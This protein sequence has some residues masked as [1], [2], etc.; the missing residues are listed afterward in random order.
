MYRYSRQA[1]SLH[2]H[3]MNE[4]THI[5]K[6][7]PV[8]CI[9]VIAAIRGRL[10]LLTQSGGRLL[11]TL[12]I[13]PPQHPRCHCRCPPLVSTAPRSIWPVFTTRAPPVARRAPRTP[14]LTV[15]RRETLHQV[16][17]G[18]G[19]Q[20]IIS[21]YS[22]CRYQQISRAQILLDIPHQ[23]VST[24]WPVLRSAVTGPGTWAG[25]WVRSGYRNVRWPHSS[26]VQASGP[27][28]GMSNVSHRSF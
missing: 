25:H 15:V 8:D 18:R 4:G 24:Q 5:L 26:P 20:L 13:T 2:C 21:R 7:R 28:V 10:P 23:D 12:T 14:R 9:T 27:C 11:L 1:F 16:S 19:P 6:C 3:W 22:K 17:P